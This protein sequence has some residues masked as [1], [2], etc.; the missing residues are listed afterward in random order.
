MTRRGMSETEIKQGRFEAAAVRRPGDTGARGAVRGQAPDR[1]V[2]MAW[3]FLALGP[4]ILFLYWPGLY[5]A[6]QYDDR[7]IIADNAALHDWSMGGGPLDA[8]WGRDARVLG[9]G[10]VRPLTVATYAL[11]YRY[12]GLETVGYHAFNLAIHWATVGALMLVMRRLGSSPAP[13][14]VAGLLFAVSPFFSEAVNYLTARSSLLAGLFSSLAVLGYAAFRRAV[15]AARPWATGA[16][17]ALALAAFG[18]ALASKETAVIIPLLWVGYDAGWSRAVPWR[19]WLAPYLIGG[20]GVSLYLGWTRYDS[21]VWAAV[22]GHGARAFWPNLWTQIG[23]LPRYLMLFVWP[24]GLS[25]YHDVSPLPVWSAEVLTGLAI[26]AGL[27]GLGIRWLV[28]AEDE[29]RIAGF[30]LIWFLVTL[31]P[32]MAYPLK[33]Q[34]QEHRAYLPGIGLAAVFGLAIWRG[35]RAAERSPNARRAAWA[36]LALVLCGFGAMTAARSAIWSD[37]LALWRDAAAKAPDARTPHLN[38]GVTL[39][40]RGQYDEADAELRRAVE[41]SPD[42]PRVYYALGVLA[43]RRGRYDEAEIL[44]RRTLA[45]A[46]DAPET[47]KM[48]AD[49]AMKQRRYDEAREWLIR[50]IAVAPDYPGTHYL[51]GE[52]E[53]KQGRVDEAEAAFRRAVEFNPRDAKAHERLGLLAQEAGNDAAAEAAYRAALRYDPDR[54]LAGNNLGTLAMKKGDWPAALEQFTIAARRDPTDVDLALNRAVALDA[55][56]RRE[57]AR[58]AADAL[59]RDLPQEPRYD[60]HRRAAELIARK[61]RP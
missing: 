34:F 48:L 44:L 8:L 55:L 30:M 13:A 11:N 6:F 54:A 1:A 58:A 45:M 5:G 39:M 56:G 3:A 50:T 17:G 24:P 14:I 26:S 42:V 40:D 35:F 49:L 33:A 18:S 23:V 28:R 20:I 10:H 31:S 29:R 60:R 9:K 57:D 61:G 15:A 19:G 38:L 53:R 41:I 7:N 4:L 21:A 27:L 12:G 51:L 2:W 37:P 32:T 43:V 16:A 36:A 52:V 25:A 46:P 22:T 47:S 59:L